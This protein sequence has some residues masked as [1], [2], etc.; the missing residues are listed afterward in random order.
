MYDPR[1]PSEINGM[2]HGQVTL[3]S[4][5]EAIGSNL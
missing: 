3:P 1:N 4:K 5:G 2:L